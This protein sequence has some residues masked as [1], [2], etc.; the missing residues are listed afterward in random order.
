MRHVESMLE[1]SEAETS[2]LQS[3]LTHLRSALQAHLEQNHEINQELLKHS[4]LE[5]RVDV[6]GANYTVLERQ[7]EMDSLQWERDRHYI[8]SVLAKHYYS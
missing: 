4:S 7:I 2:H 1:T 8:Q 3:Q 5:T 6:I